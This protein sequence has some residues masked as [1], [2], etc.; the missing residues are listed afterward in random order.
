MRSRPL[1][2]SV[3]LA[4]A[5]AAR[6]DVTVTL[7]NQAFAGFDFTLAFPAGSLQ[8][9][10]TGV[11]VDAVLVASSSYTYADDLCVY[12]DAGTLSTGGALQMGGF[13]N[14]L[15][16][17]RYVWPSGA[18]SAV[19]T[20]VLGT[21]TLV[22]PIQLTG[23]DL[24]VWIGNGYGAPGTSGAWTGTITLHG[25]TGA[26]LWYRDFDGDGFGHAPDG[27]RVAPTAPTGFVGTDGDNRPTIANPNQADANGNGIGDACEFARGDLNLDG[28]V[29]ASDIP[30]FFNLWGTTGSSP[31]DFDFDG[32]VNSS[33]FTILLN[34]WD[35]TA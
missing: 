12:L 23:S 1:A 8:G 20:P 34:N 19:G 27:V 26:S 24:H 15:A 22:Q 2:A 28:V 30:L 5:A 35:T 32:V 10:L 29:N 11:S 13:S 16:A 6:G 21:V 3:A 25:V 9:T 7:T 17:Q 14:L 18:S 33:D 31:A 4:L